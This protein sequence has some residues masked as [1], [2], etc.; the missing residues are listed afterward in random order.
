MCIHVSSVIF[1]CVF[2]AYSV[3]DPA[4]CGRVA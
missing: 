3:F 1:L 2:I 4:L